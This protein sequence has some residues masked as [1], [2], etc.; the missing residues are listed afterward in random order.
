[1]TSTPRD[2]GYPLGPLNRSNHGYFHPGM[3][4]YRNGSVNGYGQ[5]DPSHEDQY[6]NTGGFGYQQG[7]HSQFG[8]NPNFQQNGNYD[9]EF[10]PDW[11]GHQD[12]PN[13]RSCGDDSGFGPNGSYGH[14]FFEEHPCQQGPQHH[15]NWLDSGNGS[16]FGHNDSYG[17]GFVED[18]FYQQNPQHHPNWVCD[19]FNH[20]GS[21]GHR[22]TEEQ[23]YDPQ[24]RR[25]WPNLGNDSGFSLNGSSGYGFT[26]QHPCLPLQHPGQLGPSNDPSFQEDISFHEGNVVVYDSNCLPHPIPPPQ[27]ENDIP[28]NRW[29]PDD[30]GDRQ[31]APP[32][33]AE[34]HQNGFLFPPPPPP[35]PIDGR[36]VQ[37]PFQSPYGS[38]RGARGG[39]RNR[40]IVNCQQSQKNVHNKKH[41]NGSRKA[42]GSRKTPYKPPYSL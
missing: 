11:S 15:P 20:N 34:M 10:I 13:W 29:Y 33:M 16:G 36:L 37:A 3:M 31:T 18:R 25:S 24:P 4:N 2:K 39:C 28:P 8:D 9:N 38:P 22:F 21:C 30:Y 42:R 26:R 7:P 6:A 17:H 1:M 14:E 41:R 27:P 23:F 35:G 5:W 12:H 19:G 40:F 32:N